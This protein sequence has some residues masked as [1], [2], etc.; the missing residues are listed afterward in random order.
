MCDGSG[1]AG[2]QP[3]RRL[4]EDAAQ[5]FYRQDRNCPLAYEPSGEDF[6]SPCLAEADF[7]RRVLPPPA[8]PSWLTRFLPQI[9]DGRAG[10][11]APQR[12]GGPW[13][14]APGLTD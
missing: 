10:L 5:R 8:F 12:P 7:L 13:L 3:I 1:G 6:L 4:L 11:R 9:P 14:V 2:E